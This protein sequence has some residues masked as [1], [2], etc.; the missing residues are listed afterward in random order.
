MKTQ[1]FIH[2][3]KQLKSDYQPCVATIGSFDGVHC[4][5]QS[6]LA[7]IREKAD[8]LELPTMVMLFEPQPYE[9][10]SK[11]QAPARLMR[12]R[13]K[14]MALFALGVDRVVCLKFNQPFR[15]LSADEYIKEVLI[16]AAGVKSLVIGDDFRFGCGRTGDFKLLQAAGERYGFEVSDTNTQKESGERI[17]S[18]RIRKLLGDDE[19]TRAEIL[20]GK[21]YAVSGRVV[22]GKQ[23]GRTIGFPTLNIGLGRY[24]SPVEGVFTVKVRC[25]NQ[26]EN[27]TIY[28]GVAN[29]GVRPT[30]GGRRKP[31]L[32]VHLLDTNINAYG[33]R[34]EVIFLHKIRKEQKFS[35][36]DE[37]KQQI[38]QDVAA[39]K[40]YFKAAHS[41][42]RDEPNYEQ[43]LTSK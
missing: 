40:S 11:E 21:P 32:E 43:T 3:L 1:Q 12:L 26:G 5:H 9:F 41:A 34:V 29:V 30:V 20:L 6:L 25:L 7:R 13:E 39:A 37:L 36:L 10:F 4:G 35:S 28:D 33:R 16:D 14:V 17:S 15:S 38:A 8:L 31:I 27:V 42:K 18:T 24:R 22:Y 23:I 2:G 19:L